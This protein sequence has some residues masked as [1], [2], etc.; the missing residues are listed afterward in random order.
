MTYDLSGAAYDLDLTL[1]HSFY[2]LDQLLVLP[3]FLDD[4]GQVLVH[5]V[6]HLGG[7]TLSKGLT[8]PV[9]AHTRFRNVLSPLG[10]VLRLTWLRYFQDAFLLQFLHIVFDLHQVLIIVK[11]SNVI[12]IWPYAE[13]RSWLSS[14]LQGCLGTDPALACTWSPRWV[15]LSTSVWSPH[16]LC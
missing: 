4:V 13:W 14:W 16:P 6:L 11:S 5:W 3:L 8:L 2:F 7:K 10:L 9:L 1:E 15:P 12:P